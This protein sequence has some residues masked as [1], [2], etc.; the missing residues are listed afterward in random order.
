MK[1]GTQLLTRLISAGVPL[2]LLLAIAAC[3]GGGGE[4]P[5]PHLHEVP[6]GAIALAGSAAQDAA[7]TV[8]VT[9][10]AQQGQA[11]IPGNPDLLDVVFQVRLAVGDKPL[12][13]ASVNVTSSVGAVS[14]VDGHAALGVMAAN[15]DNQ[16]ADTIVLRI[17]RKQH[18]DV[19]ALSWTIAAQPAQS[20]QPSEAA[21]FGTGARPNWMRTGEL[22]VGAG[23]TT[24]QLLQ[25]ETSVGSS[26]SYRWS[27]ESSAAQGVVVE[28]LESGPHLRIDAQSKPVGSTWLVQ[29]R[30][31]HVQSRQH[32]VVP[33]VVRVVETSYM[34]SGSIG[35]QGGE[36]QSPH[37]VVRLSANRLTTP[38]NATVWITP[39]PGGAERL[40]VDFD[41]DV[42][43][44]ELFVDVP[45]RKAEDLMPGVGGSSQSSRTAGGTA[46]AL[47][48]SDQIACVI[49]R[50]GTYAAG[51]RGSAASDTLGTDI[52]RQ[53]GIYYSYEGKAVTN[54]WL[55]N[56]PEERGSFP[57]A[58][59]N[60]KTKGRTEVVYSVSTLLQGAYTLAPSCSPAAVGPA[61]F[62]RW[63]PVLFVHGY[64]TFTSLGGGGGTW[65]NFPKMVM[66]TPLTGLA[67]APA[68][69]KPL[70]FEFR[71]RTN[72]DLRLAADELGQ[73]INKIHR[74]TGKRVHVVAHS[75]GAVVLR[76]LLQQQAGGLRDRLGSPDDARAAV[77]SAVTLGA[78]NNGIFDTDSTVSLPAGNVPL[79]RGRDSLFLAACG[80]VSCQQMGQEIGAGKRDILIQKLGYTGEDLRLGQIAA[81]LHASIGQLPDLPVQAGIGL[82]IKEDYIGTD[83]TYEDGDWLIAFAGQ[84]FQ[85]HGTEA[86]ASVAALLT[87]AKIGKATVREVVLGAPDGAR[88]GQRV[89]ANI[90]ARA[91]GGYR[92]SDSN[93]FRSDGG[94]VLGGVGYEASAVSGCESSYAICNHAGYLLFRQQ[95]KDVVA[96]RRLVAEDRARTTA[97]TLGLNPAKLSLIRDSSLLPEVRASVNSL[98]NYVSAGRIR[99]DLV[100]L[101][102][103]IRLN[104]LFTG[105]FDDGPLVSAALA[106]YGLHIQALNDALGKQLNAQNTWFVT[107]ATNIQA[108]QGV[109]M[110][111]VQG[112]WA[113]AR[114]ALPAAQ[115]I[116]QAGRKI[117][118]GSRG[119]QTKLV[120]TLRALANSQGLQDAFA[121]AQC[122]PQVIDD[123]ASTMDSADGLVDEDDAQHKVLA[124]ARCLVTA[125]GDDSFKI[126]KNYKAIESLVTAS[127]EI[128]DSPNRTTVMT[129]LIAA[130]SDLCDLLPQGKVV[131]YV[132][133]I[134]DLINAGLQ[135]NALGQQIAD[136]TGKVVSM[137]QAD[138]EA[139]FRQLSQS[140]LGERSMYLLSLRAEELFTFTETPWANVQY[141]PQPLVV[142]EVSQWT[143]MGVFQS[144][145]QAI[146][147]VVWRFLGPAAEYVTQVVNGATAAVQQTFVAVGQSTVV[148][149]LRDAA[150]T[151]VG[152]VTTQVQVGVST[153]PTVNTVTPGAATAGVLATFSAAGQN[154]PSGLSFALDGCTGVTELAAGSSTTLRQFTCTFPIGSPAG[155]REGAVATNANPLTGTVLKP[156]QVQLSSPKI[157]TVSPQ[158][159]TRTVS[160]PFT[161]GA[162]DLPATGT[163]TVVPLAAAGDTRSNCQAPN[164][165]AASGFG[166]TCELYAVGAQV[167]EV[168]HNGVAMGSVSVNVNSN[169]SGV[170]WTS[171]NTGNSGAVLFGETVTYSVAGTNLLADAVMGF[172][173]EK[174]GVSNTEIGVPTNTARTFTCFF[175]RDAGAVAGQMPGVVK[176]APGGQVLLEG[177]KVPVEV[178]P[179]RAKNPVNGNEYEVIACGSWTQCRAAAQAAGGELATV[180]NQAEN[181]WIVSNLL[182][183]AKNEYGLWIGLTDEV[184]EGAWRWTSGESVAYTNW[185]VSEPNNFYLDGRPESYVHMWRGNANVV[186]GVWNDII[187][188][189][190]LTGST[191][192]TITQAIV[193]FRLTPVGKYSKFS[194]AGA[195]LPDTATGL[196]AGPNDWSCTR[197][198]TTG[199]MIELKMPSGSRAWQVYFSNLSSTSGLQKLD[200]L[201]NAVA[202]T[203]AD[204]NAPTNAA[205]YIATLNAGRLC[206]RSNWRIPSIADGPLVDLA[207]LPMFPDAVMRQG[208]NG[209]YSWISLD[210]AQHWLSDPGNADHMVSYAWFAFS[211]IGGLYHQIQQKPRSVLQP[212]R[213][214]SD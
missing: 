50:D 137:K 204:I 71:W 127:I 205:A 121:I 39:L 77:A 168:R 9:S 167:L 14:V 193:E 180:R 108:V 27:L 183:L 151:V 84:R 133:S 76:L 97:H 49:A 92:H 192:S 194:T 91:P 184:Q 33:I 146:T 52:F 113:V 209:S 4:V 16:T 94:G 107:D 88:P 89:T 138:V 125:L 12:W 38:T 124:L 45:D 62:A 166:V 17:D 20:T 51:S 11:Q 55:G 67:D 139:V 25:G 63:E 32:A 37:G 128:A 212:V 136:H 114:A 106:E 120:N 131:Q 41:S 173:V 34:R 90:G 206:G 154:L 202:A 171:P 150:N 22:V 213:G 96:M 59:S 116:N 178:A 160:S 165:R 115:V 109:L 36:I 42:S 80:Q 64:T 182:P 110:A 56:E 48:A 147:N 1:S 200:G 21:D 26:D 181:S 153:R 188:E 119:R 74:L 69:T 198:N 43:A 73:A 142:G 207:Y 199:K 162:R 130:L 148:A 44:A 10:I 3:G 112:G 169:V 104:V 98:Q 19:N 186:P 101:E 105:A 140:M 66:Q 31:T 78:P 57:R 210:E 164:N 174:C 122:S 170:T 82:A 85:N 5:K 40:T 29:L 123:L 117:G 214:I 99:W 87:E 30:Q 189:P 163:L 145:S 23:A 60:P 54:V 68:G 18:F 135:A 197:N 118:L 2:T 95:M 155:L 65:K 134:V 187:N 28:E 15:S 201:G 191:E 93:W 141:A 132:N 211:P 158:Q 79:P 13:G 175:N 61:Y 111:A 161:V 75:F 102:T 6:T 179:Q 70:P 143:L 103:R 203:L 149:L 157:E 7:G 156:F 8:R 72:V 195:V 58:K 126:S 24:R 172:A 185:R 47:Q 159:V 46:R 35:A 196:G 53:F 177:W 190:I 81:R 86:A 144:V 83:G 100:P 152:V 208:N 129:A 176:D